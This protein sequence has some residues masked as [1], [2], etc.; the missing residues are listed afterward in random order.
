MQLVMLSGGVGGAR[1]AR[2]LAAIPGAKVTVVVNTGDDDL[3]HGL[4][5]SADLDTVI[6]TLAG[7]QGPH[8]WGRSKETWRAMDELSRFPDADTSFRLGDVDL[9]VNLYRTGRLASGH[10]LSDITAD[11]CSG[12][13]ISTPVL[14]ATDDPVRT[15]VATPDGELDFQTYFVRRRHADEVIGIRFAGAD[16]ARPA[17]GVLDALHTADAVVI[18]PSNPVL[19]IWPILAVPGVGEAVSAV[20]TV[21]AVSPLIS[22]RAI[23]GPAAEAMRGV[24]LT[25]DLTGI[26]EA[27]GGVVSH[28]VIDT[29]ETTAPPTS[30]SVL[31][32]DTMIAEPEA[33]TALAQEILTWLA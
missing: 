16:Q 17:P 2:G 7:E 13:G 28:L 4:H 5:V 32:T 1:M 30:V 25:N 8:G 6:Y 26:V 14:P 23:K 19:S 18:A 24:G 33:A 12:F 9:A 20:G 29:A 31:R 21:V 11:I 10:R 27:Y 3:I 15:M 22:G